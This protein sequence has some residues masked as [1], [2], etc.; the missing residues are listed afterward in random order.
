MKTI[1]KYRIAITVVLAMT[2]GT[3]FASPNP[4]GGPMPYAR[5]A[6]QWWQWALETPT[7]QNP[8]LDPTGEF[9]DINQNGKYWLL[10]GTFGEDAERWCT[11]PAGKSL[12]FPVVNTVYGAYLTDDPGTKAIR[13]IR[14]FTSGITACT[15]VSAQ[16]D[17]KRVPI[18]HERSIPFVLHLPTDNVLGATPDQVKNLMLAPSVDEGD[19]VLLK[20]LSPGE[21]TIVFGVAAVP[22]CNIELNVIY[23]LTIE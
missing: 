14:S 5:L 21:H 12:F 13:Y 20:P 7:A 9:C 10:A 18:V 15:K 1:N 23:H 19:Y 3:L 6:A 16:L 2:A 11:I 17:G 8:V 4:S 22:D